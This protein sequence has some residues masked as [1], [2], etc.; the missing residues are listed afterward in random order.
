[1]YVGFEDNVESVCYEWDHVQKVVEEIRR[2]FD[3]YF[4][5][6]IKNYR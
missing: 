2:N 1:M 3:K 6:S 4:H 5:R